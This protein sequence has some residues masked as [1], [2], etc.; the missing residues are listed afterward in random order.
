MAYTFFLDGVQLPVTPPSLRVRIRNQNKTITL[1]NEAEVNLLKTAGLTEISFNALLP[2]APYPFATYPS[3]FRSADYYLDVL[4]RLKTRKDSA[5][6]LMPF[7]FVCSRVMPSGK[8]LFDTNFRVSLE[9]YDIKEDAGDGF[10]LTVSISLK[11][12]RDYGTK[13]VTITQPITQGAPATAQTNQARPAQ[14]APQLRTH[15]V[16]SGDT[17]WN[18]AKKNLG[19]GSRYGEIFD[20][21]KDKIKTPNLI[22]PGQVLILP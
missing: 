14:S 5:G 17:L 6:N 22:Y 16:V 19:D 12:Y 21:N 8:P 3:G 11:Q 1:I 10:D 13:T 9:E 18:I 15:T 20:L 2:Q 7:Q 4:N